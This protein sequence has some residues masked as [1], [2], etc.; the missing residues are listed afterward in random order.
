MESKVNKVSYRSSLGFFDKEAK[1]IVV[2]RPCIKKKEVQD[3]YDWVDEA[4][5]TGLTRLSIGLGGIETFIDETN[6]DSI[7][8]AARK[9]INE[10]VTKNKCS[11]STF[12]AEV[13]VRVEKCPDLRSL[14]LRCFSFVG[15][16]LI[17]DMLLRAIRTHKKLRFLDLCGCFF[18]AEQLIELASILKDTMIAQII[19]PQPLLDDDLAQ[20][21]AEKLE[22]NLSIVIIK[23]VPENV[24]KVA[25]ANRRKLFSMVK[26]PVEISYEETVILK[27]Y[28]DSLAMA[29]N[30]EQQRL[31]DLQKNIGVALA[32]I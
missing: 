27:E 24:L 17:F 11:D 6:I 16:P 3:V 14:S 21:I 31:I 9:V 13:L 1:E 29:L 32:L 28:V 22:G 15:E 19:W 25:K 7:Y 26:T 12:L 8:F 23:G 2:K 10:I 4:K 20:K 5:N 18:D 30:C